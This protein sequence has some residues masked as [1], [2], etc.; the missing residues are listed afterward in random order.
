MVAEFAKNYHGVSKALSEL[1]ANYAT[2]AVGI[3][4]EFRYPAIANR[5]V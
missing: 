2:R 3:L 5:V 4:G 1:W